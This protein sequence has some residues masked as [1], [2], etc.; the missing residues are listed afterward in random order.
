MAGELDTEA[1]LRRRTAKWFREWEIYYELEPFGELRSDYRTASIVQ[2]LYNV[3]RGKGQKALQLK[4]FLLKFDGD[5][6]PKQDQFAMLKILAAAYSS[7]VAEP[8]DV[9]Q[10]VTAEMHAQVARARAAVKES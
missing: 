2:M 5:P 1:M 7:S 10:A 4:D 8:A 3:N 9:D 6:Q